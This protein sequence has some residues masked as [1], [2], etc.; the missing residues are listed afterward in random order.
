M[1]AVRVALC[2]A[3]AAAGSDAFAPGAAL[4]RPASLGAGPPPPQALPGMR[5]ERVRT[6]SRS[7]PSVCEGARGFTS[8]IR[9]PGRHRRRRGGA[10]SGSVSI[11][12]PLTRADVGWWQ[13]AARA[14]G[15]R[16]GQRAAH[17]R[18]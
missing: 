7:R 12:R 18:S 13:Q 9:R 8:E 5:G 16:C 1:T 14:G 3:A 17:Q 2:L 4:L 11:G 6:R 10:S 15:Q